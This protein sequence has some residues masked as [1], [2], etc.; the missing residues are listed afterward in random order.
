MGVL[1]QCDCDVC[2]EHPRSGEAREHAQINR[3]LSTL[4]EKNARRVAGLLASREGHGGTALISRVT[5]M[6]RQTIDRGFDE[7]QGDDPVP[8]DRVRSVGG[9]RKAL[10]KKVPG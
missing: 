4:D 8:V 7:L 9:G 6:S 10:E 5:G 2:R 3:M 1:R